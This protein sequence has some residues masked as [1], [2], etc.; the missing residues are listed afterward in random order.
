MRLVHGREGPRPKI[1]SSNIEG[2]VNG[3]DSHRDVPSHDVRVLRIQIMDWA[4][5]TLTLGANARELVY[6][7]RTEPSPWQ[8]FSGQVRISGIVPFRNDD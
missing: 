7:E 6:G 1:N 8:F 4:L 5:P 2:T 3:K